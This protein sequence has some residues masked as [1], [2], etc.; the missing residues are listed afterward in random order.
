M[1]D[2]EKLTEI[3]LKS[4]KLPEL[5]ISANDAMD[6]IVDILDSV[7]LVDETDGGEGDKFCEFENDVQ[8]LRCKYSGGC[9]FIFDQCGYWGHKYCCKCSQAQY[10]KL[11][12]LS[13]SEAAKAGFNDEQE[14]NNH[15]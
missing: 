1:S 4:D 8:K 10:P 11:I 12:S 2:T 14:Y 5:D 13:C 15:L 7:V 6:F 9:D 3:I